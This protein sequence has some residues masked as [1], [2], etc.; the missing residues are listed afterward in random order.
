MAAAKI[1]IL[2]AII[3]VALSASIPQQE[4]GVIEASLNEG[5]VLT[6]HVRSPDNN[7]PLRTVEARGEH[8]G[9]HGD[10]ASVTYTHP[11]GKNVDVYGQVS[12]QFK[13]ND[14]S[15]HVGIRYKF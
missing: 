9:R 12:R 14:N 7:Q 8:H 6:R 1:I 15:G 13:Y 2:C 4:E 5:E 3:S 11:V 10:S